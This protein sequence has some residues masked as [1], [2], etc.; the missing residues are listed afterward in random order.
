MLRGQARSHRGIRSTVGVGL[1]AK[2]SSQSEKS[3]N[4]DKTPK[5]AT[6]NQTNS[7]YF[8]KLTIWHKSRFNSPHTRFT[9]KNNNRR[10]TP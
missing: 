2:A 7:F 10:S 3:P 9:H 8:N 5:T 1:P 6:K 4:R